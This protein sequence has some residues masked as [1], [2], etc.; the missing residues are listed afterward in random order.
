MTAEQVPDRP[1]VARAS[2]RAVRRAWLRRIT[3]GLVI[4]IA[5]LCAATGALFVWPPG[6]G[7]P[8]RVDAIVVLGGQGNR[9]GKGLELARQGRAPVLVISRGLPY[10]VPGSVCRQRSHTF[11]V[12][13]FSPRPRTTQGEAEFV[14]RL[15][16]QF[17]WRSVVL[18]VTPDQ[19]IRARIRFKRCY[20][21]QVYVV[22][23][24]LPLLEWPYQIAYQWA[25][26][27]KEEVLQRSC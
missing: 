20:A 22:T 19:V 11:T 6:R 24:P 14:S 5:L 26:E 25:A 7:M 9:L 18:V 23:T 21:G 27:F 8:A 2:G 15:A 4:V 16:R 1:E 3:A 13:C 10:P 17:H 12:I